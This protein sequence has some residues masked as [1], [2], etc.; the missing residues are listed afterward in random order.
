MQKHGNILE[1]C[2]FWSKLFDTNEK[3]WH[4]S[5]KELAAVVYSLE[6]WSKYLLGNK[7]YVFTDHKNIE[8]LHTKNSVG[9]LTN[10]KLIRWMIR[11]EH[12][13]FTCYYIQGIHNYVADYLSREI[14][15]EK[16]QHQLYKNDNDVSATASPILS[17][18]KSLYFLNVDQPPNVSTDESAYKT[19]E[20]VQLKVRDGDMIKCIYVFN[21]EDHHLHTILRRSERL[22]AK[23]RRQQVSECLRGMIKGSADETRIP[24][25]STFGVS[26]NCS[27][28]DTLSNVVDAQRLELAHTPDNNDTKAIQHNHCTSG[29]MGTEALRLRYGS[30][31]VPIADNVGVQNDDPGGAG[32][33]T[34]DVSSSVRGKKPEPDRT[35]IKNRRTHKRTVLFKDKDKFKHSLFVDEISDDDDTI[36]EL[37]LDDNNPQHLIIKKLIDDDWNDILN[38]DILRKELCNDVLC[39]SIIKVLREDNENILHTLPKPYIRDIEQGYYM[40]KNNLLYYIPE[41]AYIIPPKLRDAVIRYFHTSLFTMH[42]GSERVLNLLQN[43]FYW[44]GITTDVKDYIRACNSCKLGKNRPNQREGFMQLFPA[45]KPFETIHMDIVGPLP[46]TRNGNRYILTMMDRYSRFIKM[47]PLSV[48]TAPVIAMA[49][50]NHWLL[51]YGVPDNTLTDRGTYFTGLVFAILKKL[52]GFNTLFTTSYHPKTNGRLERFHRYLKERLRILSHTRNLDFFEKDDWD[53]YLPNIAFSYNITPNKMTGY[54]P[55][56]IIYGDIIKLPIDKI[57]KTNVIP[58]VEEELSI[59]RNPIDKRLKPIQLNALH[60]GWIRTMNAYRKHMQDEINYTTT[61]YNRARKRRYDK[62]RIPPT[63][64]QPNATVYIDESVGKTGNQ[65]K[66]PINRREATVIDKISDNVYTVQYRD[67]KVAPVNVDR[68]YIIDENKS[69]TTT[70]NTSTRSQQKRQQRRRKRQFIDNNNNN[71][72]NNNNITSPYTR[73]PPT[74]RLKILSKKKMLGK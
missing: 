2:E 26:F 48:I 60:K 64:Y 4:V 5:E 40:L 56:N 63:H 10:S 22:L 51:Q 66:L 17:K 29:N 67:G 43:R 58:T 45:T 7:F 24:D 68:M 55:Y 44:K 11:I 39:F 28:T 23:R 12:F 69:S 57:I 13:D 72:D 6:K 18:K 42:Q 20:I 1:P 3:H 25:H 47:I 14:T 9:T 37:K 71:D 31:G 27:S 41:K 19:K 50:R 73:K 38:P 62:S 53:I 8:T 65:K 30:T 36:D 70:N 59:F 35:C 21:T 54:S 16:M 32:P 74:K 52:Y 15:M 33:D 49:F 34:P 61:K 46:L